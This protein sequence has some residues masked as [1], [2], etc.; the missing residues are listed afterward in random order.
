MRFLPVLAILFSLS[1]PAAA[2]GDFSGA[3]GIPCSASC[4]A[5]GPKAGQATNGC[6]KEACNNAFGCQKVRYLWIGDYLREYSGTSYNDQGNYFLDASDGSRAAIKA[7]RSEIATNLKKFKKDARSAQGQLTALRAGGCSVAS[8]A[9]MVKGY[10]KYDSMLK[11]W[12]KMINKNNGGSSGGAAAPRL[13]LNASNTSQTSGNPAKAA[14]AGPA[15][16]PVRIDREFTEG[17][18]DV[19]EFCGFGGIMARNFFN[20][21]SLHEL[22]PG[23]KFPKK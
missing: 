13:V 17:L 7:K 18:L 12:S 22:K 14:Q 19:Y 9:A 23:E 5:Q 21:I 20:N 15:K 16:T 2:A 11:N 8:V 10:K 4:N 3:P 6:I 1:L